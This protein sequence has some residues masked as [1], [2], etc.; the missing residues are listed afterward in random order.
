MQMA[1]C[2]DIGQAAYD[3]QVVAGLLIEELKMMC[4]EYDGYLDMRTLEELFKVSADGV[5]GDELVALAAKR[6]YQ[7]VI[8][9]P[10]E[11]KPEGASS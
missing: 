11:G 8:L 2:D 7:G 10:S 6:L 5:S 9:T 3:A 4:K 1:I